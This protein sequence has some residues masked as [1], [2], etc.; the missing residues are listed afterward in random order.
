MRSRTAP[1]LLTRT[2]TR[3]CCAIARSTRLR[4]P[5]RRGEVDRAPPSRPRSRRGGRPCCA[6]PA[7]TSAPSSTS[8]SHDREADAL[9]RA[10]D[11]RDLA[12]EL[13]I[14]RADRMRES[15]GGCDS[16]HDR[17]PEIRETGSQR[18]RETTTGRGF[19]HA[20][21]HRRTGCDRVADDARGA[22][23]RARS[24]RRSRCRTRS[25]PRASRSPRQDVL[26]RLRPRP[27]AIYSGSLRTGA[28]QVDH[29]RRR[30][31]HPRRDRH[32]VRPRQALGL[33]RRRRHG[34]CL[35]RQVGRADPRVPAH[36]RLRRR[37][38][39]TPS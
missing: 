10:G 3:P 30:T 27:G 31:R 20:K 7:T 12:G 13:E 18:E 23:A 11:D 19:A 36:A 24:R 16:S 33:R 25:R 29:P 37:S 17:K 1:T 21:A 39:T 6:R 9:A 26:R 35:R 22:C 32:R 14:H 5:L 28:G 8:A 2:S 38:S 34:T 4:R 15:P